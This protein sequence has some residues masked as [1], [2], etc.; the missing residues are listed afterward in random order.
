MLAL[1][2]A[3]AQTATVHAGTIQSP[4]LRES[5]GVAVS[6]THA[7]VL[8]SHNDSGDGPFVYALDLQGRDLGA[9]RIPGAGA[10][11]WEDMTLGP[12]PPGAGAGDCLFLADVGDN[13]EVR[14]FVTVYA[15]PEPTP[16]IGPGDTTGVTAPPAALR[17][18]FP[19]GSHDVEAVYVSRRDTAL[20]LVSKGRSGPIRV[21]RAPRQAWDADSIVTVERIQT[22]PIDPD[23]R[24]GR[25]VTGAAIRPDGRL[26]AVRTLHDVYLF[27]AGIAGQLSPAARRCPIARQE[28]QGEA[29]DF[30][31]DTTLVL[32]SETGGRAAWGT[33][34]TVRC[35]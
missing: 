17:L 18:R 22:L 24:A 20:S 35:P 11:D 8:W 29:V 5:S 7:G 9:V 16:P 25:W 34:H 32:T 10:V 1:T 28:Y 15:V 4:R 6:R 27:A 30:L 31:D 23:P 21:Y 13:L 33:I 3:L 14:P 19:D 26:V 2:L 12:C